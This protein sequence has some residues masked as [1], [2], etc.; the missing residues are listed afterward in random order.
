MSR[1][2]PEHFRALFDPAGVIVAG[3]SSHPGKFGFTALHNI[4]AGGYQ[5]RIFATN[6]EGATVLG[7][8]AV[9]HP[10]ELP[11]GAADLVFVSTPVAANVELLKA[12]ATKGVRAAFVFTGGYGEAGEEGRR[13]QDELVAVAAEHDILL[14]G[15]NGQ[16]VIS[17][18][19]SLCA[20]VVAPYPPAGGIGIVSQSGN[21]TSSLMNLACHH[22]VGVSR[23]VS[24]GN[25]AAVG[26]ADYLEYLAAD[27]DTAVA[28][29][30]VEEVGDG[31]EFFGRLRDVCRRMPVVILKGGAS[32]AG[33]RAA[34]SHTGSLAT[35]DRIF[36]GACR[37]V[38]AV[39]AAGIEEA[40]EAAATFATQPLPA[41]PRVA[42]VTT[43]GGWGVVSADALSRAPTLELA[44]LPDD[45]RAALDAELPPRWS[46]NN[47]IDLAGG[48]GKDTVPQVL[49]LVTRHPGVDA[50]VFLGLGIQGNQARLERDGPFFPDH[51]LE[52]IVAFHER[53]ERRYAQ[54]AATLSEATGKPVLCAT[55]LALGDGLSP[56]V[57]GV[58]ESG[59]L[60]YLSADRAV[61]ALA[62]LWRYARWRQRRGL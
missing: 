44:P 13:A 16:G 49:E 60:C 34:A 40:Y 24:A 38:G 7:V 35:D 25:A 26:V 31:S 17:T 57:A 28:L 11:E 20:Q 19:S 22:G 6:L 10:S 61:T 3:A 56:A 4:L 36:D 54:T 52:R 46:R 62:H 47:P 32:A 42:V 37:Q 39:R 21:L 1:Y 58:R 55:E 9:R 12:C 27:P 59:R 23:A 50:V 30:Y 2:P 51:G 18:P 53:Q 15:P 5:G 43:A 29:V 8:E 48:E 41:G 14:A 45:L 33:A